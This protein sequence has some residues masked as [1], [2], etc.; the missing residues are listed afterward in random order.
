MRNSYDVI[1]IDFVILKTVQIFFI[2]ENILF[3]SINLDLKHAEPNIGK[4][5]KTNINL[6]TKY[7]NLNCNIVKSSIFYRKNIDFK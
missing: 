1:E 6:I 3:L 2:S 7:L 5:F 4:I